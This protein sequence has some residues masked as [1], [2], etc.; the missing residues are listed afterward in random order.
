MSQPTTST[1]KGP[2]TPTIGGLSQFKEKE[3]IPWTGGKP[4]SD[5]TDLDPKARKEPK[6]QHQLRPFSFDGQRS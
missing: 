1:F 5:R 4:N 3:I 2:D 6:F